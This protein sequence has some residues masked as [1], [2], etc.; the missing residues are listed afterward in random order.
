[1]KKVYEKPDAEEMLVLSENVMTAS[2]EEDTE[3]EIVDNEL[4][5]NEVQ[6]FSL[7]NR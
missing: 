6:V 7:L 1:M 3:E 5:D 4:R 2:G